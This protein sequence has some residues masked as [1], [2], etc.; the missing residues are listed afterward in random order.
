MTSFENK[1]KKVPMAED[2]LRYSHGCEIKTNK[3]D[4]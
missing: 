3:P 4:L 1:S 2:V